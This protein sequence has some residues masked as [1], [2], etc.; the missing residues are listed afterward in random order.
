MSRLI[1]PLFRPGIRRFAEFSSEFDSYVAQLGLRKASEA[2][3]PRF[4]VPAEVKGAEH[5]PSDGPLLIAANHP[6]AYDGFILA[7]KLARNDLK[8]VA[9]SYEFIRRLPATA[10]RFIFVSKDPH[11]RMSAIRASIRQLREKGSLLIFPAGVVE[12]DPDVVPGLQESLSGWSPSLEIMLR[13]VPETK[14]VTAIISGVLSTRWF[15]K[16]ITWF[17]KQPKHSQAIAEVFQVMQQFFFPNSLLLAPR[18]TFDRPAT[19]DELRDGDDKGNVLSGLIRRADM[20]LTEHMS[21][22]KPKL[23]D[24]EPL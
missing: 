8:I 9:S 12:P 19:T 4:I 18:V 22:R 6:G 21:W 15:R 3:L 2:V 10:E 13:K 1:E 24:D 17:S 23:T 5:V 11:Q 20:L 16:P 7:S 14:V